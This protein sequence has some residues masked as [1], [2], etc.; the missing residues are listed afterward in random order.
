MYN[1]E[2]LFE[3]IKEQSRLMPFAT[4]DPFKIRIKPS[5]STYNEKT[6]ESRY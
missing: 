1:M 3:I 2:I 6:R 5:V 4:K